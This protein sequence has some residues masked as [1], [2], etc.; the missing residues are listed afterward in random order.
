M[1]RLSRRRSARRLPET[2]LRGR[3]GGSAASKPSPVRRR[4]VAAQGALA[5]LE[6][7][8]GVSAV[9]AACSPP[10]EPRAKNAIPSRLPRPVRT[11]GSDLPTT[12]PRCRRSTPRCGTLDT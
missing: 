3:R 1:T 11:I 10:V 8:T 9:P 12:N 7:V 4:R 2:R 6:A 5:S